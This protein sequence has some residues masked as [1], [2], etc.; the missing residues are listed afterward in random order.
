M[1]NN[2][3]TL[4]IDGDWGRLCPSDLVRSSTVEP[5]FSRHIVDPDRLQALGQINGKSLM[6]VKPLVFC[7]GGVCF[8]GTGEKCAPPFL[9]CLAK[10]LNGNVS[11]RNWWRMIN[12]VGENLR[13][14]KA[15]TLKTG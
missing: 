4:N 13:S 3:H 8:T 6:S 10:D 2:R 14:V 11:W 9:D 1:T 5:L 15:K 12:N 7:N